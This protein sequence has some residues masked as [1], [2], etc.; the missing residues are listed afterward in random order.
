MI[1]SHLIYKE[2]YTIKGKID[3]KHEIKNLKT[4]E[5]PLQGIKKF[6]EANFFWGLRIFLR[7]TRTYP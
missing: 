5:K 6:N 3:K 2:A 1:I 4:K 7:V